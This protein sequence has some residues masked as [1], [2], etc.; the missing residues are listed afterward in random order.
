MNKNKARRVIYYNTN[1]I[2][3]KKMKKAVGLFFIC[4]IFIFCGCSKSASGS[5]A[6]LTQRRW[7]AKLEGGGEASL[8]FS[9]DRAELIMSSGD[10]REVIEGEYIADESAFVIFDKPI[11]RNYSFTYVPHGEKLELT[12]EGGTIEMTAQND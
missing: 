3:V 7:S 9:G 4:V 12:F 6:E 5:V 11:C 8:S 10:E 1:M 2:A